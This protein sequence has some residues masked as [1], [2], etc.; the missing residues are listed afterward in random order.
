MSLLPYYN[1]CIHSAATQIPTASGIAYLL[2]PRSVP[3]GPDDF[4]AMQALVE[5]GKLR[6]FR[7]IEMKPQPIF[8]AEAGPFRNP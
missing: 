7:Y 1:H 6:D 4:A 2:P 8:L 5:A 3:P